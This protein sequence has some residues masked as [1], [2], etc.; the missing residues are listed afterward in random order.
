MFDLDIISICSTKENHSRFFPF[1]KEHIVSPEAY[2]ILKDLGVWFVKY[3]D[4][5][6]DDFTTWFALVKHSSHTAQQKTLY[7]TIFNKLKAHTVSTTVEDEVTKSLIS[8]DY[9]TKIADIA[10]GISEG[11]DK[12]SMDDVIRLVDDYQLEIDSSTSEEEEFVTSDIY[13][14]IKLTSGANGLNWRIPQLNEAMGP[15][16]KS[17]FVVVGSRPDSGKTSFLASEATFM[18]PQMDEGDC[19]LWFNNE[20]GGADIKSRI[21]QAGIGWNSDDI[22]YHPADAL[23]EFEKVVGKLDRIKVKDNPTITTHYIE[24]LIKKYKPGLIIF[25]QLWKV[26]GFTREATNE[27]QRQTML[28]NWGR[29]ICKKHAPVITVHQAGGVAG[30]ER[31]IPMEQLYGSQT[32][33]QGEADAIITIGRT[34]DPTEADMRFFYLPKNKMR[35][36]TPS[37]RNGRFVLKFD[38]DVG[39]FESDNSFEL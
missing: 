6:W 9:A 29:E 2:Q 17:K 8:R 14:I 24:Q 33:I 23:K 18:L 25:D 1:I 21:I 27:V 39:R 10:L 36:S 13:E 26:H 28:F 7:E 20:E 30:G 34:Y 16:R 19:I 32:G 15:I 38:P 12:E 22:R 4:L 11:S 5:S 31:W 35:G 3:D 37:Q